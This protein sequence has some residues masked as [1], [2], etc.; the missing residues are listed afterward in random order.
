MASGGSLSLRRRSR[1]LI[2]LNGIPFLVCTSSS[3]FLP[4]VP[5]ILHSD[6]SSIL[7][8][9]VFFLQEG[10][11]RILLF[12]YLSIGAWREGRRRE[13]GGAHIGRTKRV[14]QWQGRVIYISLFFQ[15][16]SHFLWLTWRLSTK[17]ISDIR[18]L[19]ASSFRRLDD[20]NL[21][22]Q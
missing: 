9:V 22:K 8:K 4:S 11:F 13:G 17:F 5:I 1:P 3:T 6:K 10:S 7:Q 21:W 14:S 19:V 20:I 16:Y 12:L 18:L 15:R 2:N